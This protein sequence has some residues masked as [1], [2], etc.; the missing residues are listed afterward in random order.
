MYILVKKYEDNYGWFRE[1]VLA[2]DTFDQ[3]FLLWSED[4]ESV[5]QMYQIGREVSGDEMHVEKIN[6]ARDKM[7]RRSAAMDAAR[8]HLTP[9]QLKDLGLA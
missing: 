5:E 7:A 8:A 2:V 1:E 3:L 9:E 6:R 4:P